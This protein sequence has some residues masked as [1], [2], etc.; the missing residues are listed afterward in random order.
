VIAPTSGTPEVSA[1]TLAGG[2]A[3]G[4]AAADGV[5]RW[6]ESKGR[7]YPTPAGLV[8]I[9]PA[10]VVYDLASGDPAAR[11][12]ADEGAAACEAAHDGEPERGMVGAG[13]G[14]AVG[15]LFGRENARPGGIGFAAAPT[16]SGFHVAVIAVANAFGDVI[17]EHGKVLAGP[18]DEGGGHKRSAVEL[19]ER[20][21]PPSPASV[22]E[23]NTTLACVM[24]DAPLGKV[25]C[26]R[27]ARMAAAGVARAVDPVFSDVDG[28]VVFCL[29]SGEGDADRFDGMVVGTLAA[30]LTAAAIRDAVRVSNAPQG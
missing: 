15:K 5:A 30:T 3:F 17:D 13:A 20:G 2:S 27:A 29:A 25:G 10:A 23:Q 14:T 19:V 12:G 1:V 24:T 9:V 8:P 26:T 7:G 22:E 6:L 28:D 4:L 11:P 18:L 21:R 16:G